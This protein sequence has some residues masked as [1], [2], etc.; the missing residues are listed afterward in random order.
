MTNKLPAQKGI[1]LVSLIILLAIVFALLNVYAYYNPKFSLAR[2]SPLNFLK[3]GRD[4]IRTKDLDKLEK[5]VVAYYNDK[6]QMPASDGWCGRIS[7]I[8]HPEFAVEIKPYL[9]NS[10][11]PHDP[12]YGSTDRDY[13]YYRVDKSHFI[14][15]AAL[16]LPKS[17]TAGKYNYVKCFDWP[18][19]NI[20]NYQL[21]NLLG[22]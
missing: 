5:A 6:N 12:L 16:E 9:E 7:G 22:N 2:Y 8:L 15:M 17:E 21:T 20:Y 14:L 11:I 18:G 3:A 13:F 19:D 1:G 4:S 10:E